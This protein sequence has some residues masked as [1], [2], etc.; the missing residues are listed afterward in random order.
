MDPRNQ[1]IGKSCRLLSEKALQLQEVGR[2]KTGDLRGIHM[3]RR[4]M[5]R[6]RAMSQY[7]PDSDL[8]LA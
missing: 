1:L 2:A 4:R 8:I 6:V 5:G 7:S 3:Y